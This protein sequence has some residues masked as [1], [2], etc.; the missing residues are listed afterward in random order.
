MERNKM[1]VLYHVYLIKVEKGALSWELEAITA[2]QH[3]R[4]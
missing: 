1:F 3:D 2:S 4:G